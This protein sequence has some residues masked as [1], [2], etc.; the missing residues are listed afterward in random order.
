MTSR[1]EQSL[2]LLIARRDLDAAKANEI[3]KLLRGSIDW[4]YLVETARQHGLIPLLYRHL[5][6]LQADVPPVE[7]ERIKQETVE[8]SQSVLYLIDQLRLL[9]NRFQDE[10]LPVLVFKGPI[11]SQLAYGE[12][13]LRAAGDLDLLIERREYVRARSILESL[14]FQIAPS[15]NGAQQ[16]AHLGFHCEIQF[17]RDNWFT[18]VDLHWSLTP[19]VFPFALTTN[20]LMARAQ[21]VSLAG[22]TVNTFGLEDLIL[23]LSMHGAKHY[24]QRLEWISSLAEMIR[25]HPEIDWPALTN[26]ARM[27]RGVRILALG[28]HLAQRVGEIEIPESVFAEID[29]VGTMKK[30]AEERMAELFKPQRR[31]YRSVA[32]VRENLKI[33]DRR[34]DVFTSLVRAVFVPTISDWETLTLPKS[35]HLLYYV[36]R[37][38]RLAGSYVAAVWQTFSARAGLQTNGASKIR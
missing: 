1:G 14:G 22:V 35:L 27:A 32:A 10:N 16:A 3:R 20:E 17:M 8:N 23:F 28:L 38:F 21:P 5:S 12:M 11:L 26:L 31:E 19:K 18:V 15:L 36:L 37:P 9:L 29:R 6:A 33:M 13:S 34:R 4:N 2:L 7:F 30:V 24:W 25:S